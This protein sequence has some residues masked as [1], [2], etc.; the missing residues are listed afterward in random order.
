MTAGLDA[1]KS[2]RDR[3]LKPLLQPPASG[4]DPFIVAL[5]G[6]EGPL[7]LLLALAREQK[8][9]LLQISIEALADQY[10]GFIR[11]AQFAEIEFAAEYLVMAAWLAYLKSRLLLP[12][13][14]EPDAADGEEM[15]AA[16]QARL[17]QLDIMQAAAAALVRRPRLGVHFFPRGAAGVAPEAHPAPGP[18]RAD[19]A[20]LVAAYAAVLK[21]RARRQPL[22]LEAGTWTSIEEAIARIRRSLGEAP[23]WESLMR[24]L[25]EETMALLREGSL[26]GRSQLAA[27][28]AAILELAKEGVLAVRQARP[29]GPIFVKAARQAKEPE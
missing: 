7:D 27:T 14:G 23:G 28:L 29:F 25:P 19:R 2:G 26:A 5:D 21:A 22:T 6:Y 13:A 17:A 1:V 20:G 10:L 12:A 9:D 18:V 8:V 11:R 24:Y 16:L 3:A 15:A 4:A